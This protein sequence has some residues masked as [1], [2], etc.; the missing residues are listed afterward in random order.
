MINF[1]SLTAF[2]LTSLTMGMASFVK[3]AEAVIISPVSATASSEFSADFDIGNTIDQSGLSI[4]FT[5]GVTDF[6]TYIA[7]NPTHTVIAP[8]FEWFTPEDVTTATV[9]YD[10]GSVFSIDRLALWNEEGAG[11]N[12]FNLLSSTDGV[13]FSTI[14]SGVSPVDNPFTDYPA[15]VISFGS[16]VDAQFIQFDITSCP[17]VP[18]TFNGCAIGE[19]AFSQGTTQ[20]IPFEAETSIAL[21]LLG[22]YMG[23]KKFRQRKA[24]G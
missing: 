24:K 4:G 18:T 20:P 19:V 17:Q 15:E 10:L 16:S 21:A 14:L 3:P 5:S 11:I 22:G 9:T 2:S 8:G 6:D 1:K 12:N 7:S 23:V 13:N